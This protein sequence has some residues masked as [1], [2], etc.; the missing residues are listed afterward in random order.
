MSRPV[1]VV[2]NEMANRDLRLKMNGR[3]N[4]LPMEVYFHREQLI[5]LAKRIS[6]WFFAFTH[7]LRVGVLSGSVD[8]R[9]NILIRMML[10]LVSTVAVDPSCRRDIEV[11]QSFLLYHFDVG[12]RK[13]IVFLDLNHVSSSS[14]LNKLLSSSACI[15][16]HLRLI[17]RTSTTTVQQNTLRVTCSRL[18]DHV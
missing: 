18:Y 14:V 13:F 8:T 4:L 17:D 6:Q 9:A 10:V 7:K 5:G 16:P 2:S 3:V 15:I 1:A 11:L 12:F